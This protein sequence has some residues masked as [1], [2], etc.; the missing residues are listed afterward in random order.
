MEKIQKNVWPDHSWYF[1]TTST[2]LH[3]PFF[4]FDE[5]KI[6]VL[7]RLKQVENKFKIQIDNFSIAMTHLHHLFYLD[8]GWRY[9]QIMKFINGGVSYDYGRK[10]EKKYPQIWADNKTKIIVN[11]KALWQVRGYIAGN[12]LKHLEVNNF[13]EL[14]ASRFSSYRKLKEEYGGEF[15]RSLIY[16]TIKLPEGA[17]GEVKLE[18]LDTEGLKSLE[19]D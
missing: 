10:F 13:Y 5:Q 18:E 6:L 17:D 3:F 19:G 16:E 2:F 12:L 1:V 15:A 8:N 14:E 11:E 4:R 9:P 7:D